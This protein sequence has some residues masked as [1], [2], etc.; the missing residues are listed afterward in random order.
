MCARM[1]HFATGVSAKWLHCSHSE[2]SFS[3]GG[4]WDEPA[5]RR[6]AK[7]RSGPEHKGAEKGA[8]DRSMLL[9]GLLWEGLKQLFG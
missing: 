6:G 8:T 3:R 2:M 7:F 4:E 5:E 9:A 1:F